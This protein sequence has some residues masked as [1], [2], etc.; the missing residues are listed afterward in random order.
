M[1]EVTEMPWRGGR[2]DGRKPQC[3]LPA[4]IAPKQVREH[5]LSCFCAIEKIVKAVGNLVM[6]LIVS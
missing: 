1:F 2:A 3:L 6:K 4:L 5:C